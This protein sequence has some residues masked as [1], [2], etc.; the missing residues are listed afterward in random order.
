MSEAG[1]GYTSGIS[2]EVYVDR[3]RFV[4]VQ[5]QGDMQAFRRHHQHNELNEH[6]IVDGIAAVIQHFMYR[7]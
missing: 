4:F 7:K 6:W 2:M 5:I 3:F 1:P